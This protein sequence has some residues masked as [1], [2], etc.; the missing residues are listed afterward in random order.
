MRPSL[1]EQS[2]LGM[3]ATF[4][5]A[6]VRCAISCTRA[7]A[8]TP[9]NP[10]R[11]FVGIIYMT[12][13]Y[14]SLYMLSTYN[15]EQSAWQRRGAQLLAYSKGIKAPHQSLRAAVIRN[16]PVLVLLILISCEN[17]SFFGGQPPF[18]ETR[19]LCYPKVI[20]L[21]CGFTGQS[22]RRRSHNRFRSSKSTQNDGWP[23]S[24]AR[25]PTKLQSA[26]V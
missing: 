26:A 10:Q 3:V 24:Q 17:R 1:P 12:L 22:S 21:T 9:A 15:R 16:R 13:T 19:R 14:T 5:F 6:R 20:F 2:P 25:F 7:A 4:R 18:C 11:G 8:H 23:P